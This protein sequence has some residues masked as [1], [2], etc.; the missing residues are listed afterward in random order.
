MTPQKTQKGHKKHKK[1]NLCFLW[2]LLR[3]LLVNPLL[4]FDHLG[5][6]RAF[7][8]LNPFD[9]IELGLRL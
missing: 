5:L 6:F 7:P 1:D 3:F 9:L 4:L 8:L 2:S